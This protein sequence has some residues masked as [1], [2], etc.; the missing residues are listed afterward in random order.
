VNVPVWCI[1]L[2]ASFWLKTGPPPPFPRDLR[3]AVQALP[4]SVIELPELS[5]SRILSWFER[6]GL[7][8]PLDQPDRPL[9]ACLVAWFGEGFAFLDS[10][11]DP[12]EKAF[13]LAHELAHFLRDYL[14]PREVAAKRLG[15]AALE[16]LDGKR[17]ASPDERL[18]AVLRNIRLGPFTHLLKRDDS[19][20]SLMPV[21]WEA[22]LAADRLAFEL[23]APADDVG[24]AADRG[25]LAKRLVHVFGLPPLAAERYAATLMAESPA[26]DRAI[27]RLIS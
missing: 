9:R 15:K 1:D 22:E 16:V 18:H 17:T 19:R 24:E 11:D 3:D 27:S 21:E 14:H 8:I 23:L 12:T 25:E 26:I 10:R 13:S 5:V 6:S 7:P 2:A 20:Q 4:L